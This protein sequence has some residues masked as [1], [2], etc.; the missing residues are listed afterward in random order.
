[1]LLCTVMYVQLKIH[2]YEMN[3][4]LHFWPIMT[5]YTACIKNTIS[6]SLHDFQSIHQIQQ[7]LKKAC[8]SSGIR[9]FPVNNM[10]QAFDV[11]Q[12]NL[13][14]HTQQTKAVIFFYVT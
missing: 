10:P 7:N 9:K 8:H 14:K 1:M 11:E 13:M 5:L 2:L 4:K 12:K 6:G 3:N